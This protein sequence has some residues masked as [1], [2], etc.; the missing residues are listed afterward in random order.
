V[1]IAL[2]WSSTDSAKFTL[3]Y[4]HS[5]WSF[6]DGVAP[7]WT[8]FNVI[9]AS[10]KSEHHPS[11]LQLCKI[12]KIIR[13]EWC[14]ARILSSAWNIR[15]ITK[16]LLSF[17]FKDEALVWCHSIDFDAMTPFLTCCNDDDMK[18]Q[19]LSYL[20]FV[21]SRVGRLN[22][23]FNIEW[24]LIVTAHLSANRKLDK[25]IILVI[26]L[27]HSPF[28]RVMSLGK[29]MSSCDN[30]M[31]HCWENFSP[32]TSVLN[33]RAN[34]I[35]YDS[36]SPIIWSTSLRMEFANW[37]NWAKWAIFR[38]LLLIAMCTDFVI[39]LSIW[40]RDISPYFSMEIFLKE[41]LFR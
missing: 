26:L 37:A 23:P 15:P 20:N 27:S 12:G 40:Y 5:Q 39:L 29:I 32:S 35:H 11:K 24:I 36:I 30:W 16:N 9:I 22:G 2:W 14:S 34:W 17:S 1:V 19:D 25:I 6:I 13:H 31:R 38:I 3:A 8:Y 33:F 10:S 21:S 41:R 4:S 28:D 7:R 18:I